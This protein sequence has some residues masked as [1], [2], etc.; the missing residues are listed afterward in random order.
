MSRYYEMEVRIFGANIQ[1]L[2][3]IEQAARHEWPFEA[4]GI[5]IDFDHQV[6]ELRGE[7]SLH[8]SEDKF[9]QR[10]SQAIW[11]ANEGYCKVSINATDLEDIPYN[12]YELTPADFERLTANG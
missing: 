10:L 7:G 6:L 8:E 5:Y 2:V 4:D 3:A 11:A 9:A 1:R 12:N